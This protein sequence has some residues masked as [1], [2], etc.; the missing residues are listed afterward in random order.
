L[1]STTRGYGI[2][3][4]CDID[5]ISRDNEMPYMPRR[6]ISQIDARTGE[7]LDGGFVAY[8]TPKRCNGFG[9]G[10]MA[11][12]QEASRMLSQRRKEIGFEAFAVMHFLISTA[13]FNGQFKTVN[14]TQIAKELDMQKSNVSRA[15]KRLLNFGVLVEGPREGLNKA[16]AISP[17]I[18]WKGEAKEHIIALHDYR[19]SREVPA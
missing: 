17:E 8:V 4:L 3:V 19:R 11:L 9:R 15:I 18:A 14:Q 1:G 7:V 2:D 6:Q 10:W 5:N 12:S 13:E 16:Y